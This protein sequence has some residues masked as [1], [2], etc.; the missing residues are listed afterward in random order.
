MKDEKTTD[1]RIF[2]ILGI[3]LFAM[4]ISLISAVGPAFIIFLGC[5]VVYM[6][7]GL[8]NRDK[9]AESKGKTSWV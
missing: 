9:W 2:F 6:V 1:Y 5:G 7:I 3:S 8:A 4:G